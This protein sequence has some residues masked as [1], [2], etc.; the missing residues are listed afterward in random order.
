MLSHFKPGFIKLDP[1]FMEDLSKSIPN[2]QKIQELAHKARELGI[3]G[4]AAGVQDANSMS[5]LFTSGIDYVEGD[6]LAQSGPD[7]NY[8]FES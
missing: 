2:Q 7:M 8:E 3:L 4:I 6:F 1:S 5:S